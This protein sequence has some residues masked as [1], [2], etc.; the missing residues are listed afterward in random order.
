MSVVQCDG[1]NCWMSGVD[2]GIEW[3]PFC[4]SHLN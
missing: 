4:S 2:G 1:R 3:L